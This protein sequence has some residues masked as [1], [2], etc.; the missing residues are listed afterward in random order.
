V[1]WGRGGK[2]VGCTRAGM[3]IAN[4]RAE[5]NEHTLTEGFWKRMGASTGSYPAS[6]NWLGST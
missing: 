6:Y 2:G 5:G 4:P 1:M 3:M